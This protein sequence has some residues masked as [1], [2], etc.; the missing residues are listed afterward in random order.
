MHAVRHRRRRAR[1]RDAREDDVLIKGGTP[2]RGTRCGCRARQ[3]RKAA[4]AEACTSGGRT[5]AKPGER[6]YPET[7]NTGYTSVHT[8]VY[9]NYDAPTNLFL[10][11]THVDLQQRSTQCLTRVQPRLRA[12]Q[13]ASRAPRSRART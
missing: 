8:D 3:R 2:V 10:P 12:P 4:Q 6:V 7:G 9:I 5:L 1:L 13:H 11:G